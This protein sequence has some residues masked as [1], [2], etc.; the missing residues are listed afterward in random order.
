MDELETVPSIDVLKIAIDHLTNSKAPWSDNIPPDL[1]KKCK[2]AL[3]LPVHN[4]L[5]QYWQEGE[6]LQDMRDA[7]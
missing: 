6:V 3:L 4:I 2:S 1:I 5:Y 7:K